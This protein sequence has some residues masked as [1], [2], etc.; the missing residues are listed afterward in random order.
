MNVGMG[1]NLAA[2]A[3]VGGAPSQ[4]QVNAQVAVAG[5][6]CAHQAQQ[7]RME[8]SGRQQS[9][10]LVGAKVA[11]KKVLDKAGVTKPAGAKKAG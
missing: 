11:V 4:A 2:F 1:M 8:K 5:A 9:M 6:A 3:R 10:K 7:D